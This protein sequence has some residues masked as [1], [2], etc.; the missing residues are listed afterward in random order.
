MFLMYILKRKLASQA[1]HSIGRL[2]VLASK[3]PPGIGKFCA[4]HQTSD[5]CF[6]VLAHIKP[7]TGCRACKSVV[8]QNGAC[9]PTRLLK[10]NVKQ[11]INVWC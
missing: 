6:N 10:R 3:A 9:S 2:C 11:K 7:H 4:R 1:L 5:L 8:E